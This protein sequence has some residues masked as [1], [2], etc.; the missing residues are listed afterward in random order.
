MAAHA[1]NLNNRD[2]ALIGSESGANQSWNK[3]ADVHPAK[4][5]M[6]YVFLGKAMKKIKK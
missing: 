2:F 6:S 3:K 5:V 1:P 4:E